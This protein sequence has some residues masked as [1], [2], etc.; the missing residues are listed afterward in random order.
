VY[1]LTID[2]LRLPDET[3]YM[4]R[5]RFDRYLA[6][7]RVVRANSEGNVVPID[8][9]QEERYERIKASW[10]KTPEARKNR[11]PITIPRGT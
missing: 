10:G 11:L 4:A 8:E 6:E 1:S 9:T 2:D 3:R 5:T 7:G